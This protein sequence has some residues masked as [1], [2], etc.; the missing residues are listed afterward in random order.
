ML[1]EILEKFSNQSGSTSGSDSTGSLALGDTLLD[2]GR[3]NAMARDNREAYQAN[4]PFPHVVVDNFL[5]KD[6]LKIVL[7]AIP[8]PDLSKQKRDNSAKTQG[9]MKAQHGKVGLNDEGKLNPVMR[10]LFWEL[11][12][13]GFLRFLQRLTD[14]DGLLPDPTLRGGGVHQTKR[15]GLLRV[16][17]DF[18]KHP[19]YNLDRRINFI[20]YLNPDWKEEYGGHLELWDRD[21]T[22]CQSR[23]LP[24]LNRCVIFNT[25]SWSF[26]G[27]PH[28]LTCPDDMYRRSIAMYYY[29]NGR[30]A[31][32]DSDE[33]HATIW[34]ALPGET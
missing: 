17:A 5:S 13:Q 19:V 23:V 11:N 27:H 20:L 24:I 15:G 8:E 22:E 30:P 3:L 25:S 4:T 2:F 10:Q 1:K 28:P 29:S 26:H 32:D 34:P 18:N 6:S 12:S 21:V 33:K 31:S 7:D 16:H 9:G 14:I